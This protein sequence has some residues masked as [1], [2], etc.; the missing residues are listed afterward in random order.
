M[1][2]LEEIGLFNA[3][4]PLL[5]LNII[6][7]LWPFFLK[8]GKAGFK[9]LADYSY[10]GKKEEVIMYFL[11]VM[12]DI[13]MIIIGLWIPLRISSVWFFIGIGIMIISGF[14]LVISISNFVQT[15]PNTLVVKGFYKISRNPQNL[16]C[17]IF[18]L[19]TSVASL[20]LILFILCVLFFLLSRELIKS[21]EKYCK[22]RYGQEFEKYLEKTHRYFWW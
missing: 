3:W 15:P 9:R 12:K 2:E 14:C 19:G 6:M 20:S 13:G 16:F 8:N 7:M 5:L 4:M 17:F 11:Y 1:F 18:I 10:Y 22:G 21:E